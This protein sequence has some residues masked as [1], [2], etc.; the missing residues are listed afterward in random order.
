[1]MLTLGWRIL[2]VSQIFIRRR[3]ITPKLMESKV[4]FGLNFDLI[5]I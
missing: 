1:M 5:N 3:D 2:E 4:E